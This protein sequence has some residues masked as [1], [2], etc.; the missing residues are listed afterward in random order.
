MGLQKSWLGF[1]KALGDYVWPHSL[2]LRASNYCNKDLILPLMDEHYCVVRVNKKNASFQLSKCPDFNSQREPH[3]IGHRNYSASGELEKERIPV[4]E[5]HLIFHHKHLFVPPG[6]EGFNTDKAKQWSLRWKS[7]L[8]SCRAVSSRIGR[9][10]GW[11]EQLL[12]Y[13]LPLK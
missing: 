10:N 5:N 9:I 12:K 4:T 8:P 6:Y 11:H 7:I 3:I 1:G 2:G 13:G